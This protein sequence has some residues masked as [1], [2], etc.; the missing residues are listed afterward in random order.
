MG[1][2]PDVL[3]TT[4]QNQ[5][6]S[7]IERVERLEVD[8]TEVSELIKEVYAEAKGNG[9]D[10]KVLKKVVRLRRQDHAK[11]QE[12]EAILDLYLSALGEDSV[13]KTA[14]IATVT[15]H[16]GDGR[17]VSATPDAMNAAVNMIMG[18]PEQQALYEQAVEIVQR[19]GK[20]STSYIQ[21][22]LQINFNTAASLVERMQANGVIGPPDHT[23]KREVRA[24]A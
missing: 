6:R 18:A 14:G 15:L 20:A 9:F 10:V 17:S 24:A 22:K 4:A 11:R 1:A 8:K 21:R 19:D 5:L 7:V 3:N 16:M 13:Q 2:Q 12:E 23:G